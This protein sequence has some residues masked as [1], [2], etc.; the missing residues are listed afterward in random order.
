MAHKLE[1]AIFD[2]RQ[3]QRVRV[4]ANAVWRCALVEDA[5]L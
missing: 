2:L 1:S 4:I 5:G 3:L